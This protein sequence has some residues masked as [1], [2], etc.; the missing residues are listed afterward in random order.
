[1]DYV[2]VVIQWLFGLLVLITPGM[3]VMIRLTRREPSRV[4]FPLFLAGSFAISSLLAAAL[5]SLSLLFPG[6][7]AARVAAYLIFIMSLY[8][9][10]RAG[11]KHLSRFVRE[12]STWERR[13]LMV[14]LAV[15][16]FWLVG[17]PLSQYP[18]Q[19]SVMLGDTPV[20]YRQATNLAEGRGWE[21]DYFMA[22][23]PGGT[24][25]YVPAHPI[26][27]YITTQFFHI[28]GKNWYSLYVYNAIAAQILICLFAFVARH[29][30]G[31][32]DNGGK[33]VFFLTLVAAL[34]PTHFVLFGLGSV[35]VPGALM[36]LTIAATSIHDDIQ[37]RVRILLIGTALLLSFWL[38]PEA[39]FL[40]VIL[41]AL[42][43]IRYLFVKILTTR[44]TRFA[45]AAAGLIVVATLWWNLPKLTANSPAEWNSLAIFH[46]KY[47]TGKR[48]FVPMW[49]D[50][51]VL[52]KILCRT[53]LSGKTEEVLG[54]PNIGIE[55]R[56][57]PLAFLRF[58]IGYV[59]RFAHLFVRSLSIAHWRIGWLSGIPSVLILSTFIALSAMNR[60]SRLF[61]GAAAIFLLIMP[62]LNAAAG[63]R[64]ILVV[65][66]TVMALSIRQ[67]MSFRRN[68]PRW[69]IGHRPWMN[70]VRWATMA[71]LL[72]V[73]LYINGSSIIRIRT[74]EVNNCYAGIIKDI[75]K[76]A[77][78]NDL[79]ASNYPQLITCMTGLRSVGGPW[80][81]ENTYYL[82]KNYQPDFIV[83]DDGR[84]GVLDYTLLVH[85]GNA[86]PSYTPV[87]H[88]VES[89]YII[90]RAAKHGHDNDMKSEPGLTGAGYTETPHENAA[91]P[92]LASS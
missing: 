53:N 16:L 90:F 27:V 75:E 42:F 81:L 28:F 43:G 82:L 47:I 3:A 25:A 2:L 61:A 52:N 66:A 4:P 71:V 91:T 29:V 9:F 64:H 59:P 21:T 23:Y 41:T 15:G 73:V 54:N 33:S 92:P 74:A 36:F 20:Y 37:G 84:R 58:L 86:L 11:R 85:F 34:V 76:L 14:I 83:I 60:K 49:G 67:I 68:G 1:M 22:D 63:V 18:S 72:S 56:D 30:P 12:M 31:M 13:S 40:A 55:L 35:T 88:N 79:I 7:A 65:S 80:L 32:N 8:Y 5:Q 70:K 50:P 48:Q 19:V 26:P 57:H 38:R 77:A 6:T 51:W 62:L 87:I 45:C 78:P 44:K 24:L 69:A 17:M 89:R 10:V 46:S 39:A